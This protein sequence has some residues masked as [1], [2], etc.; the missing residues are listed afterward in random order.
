[1]K[2]VRNIILVT[3]AILVG[4]VGCGSGGDDWIVGVWETEIMGTKM[5]Y[6]FETDGTVTITSDGN[7]FGQEVN[8][9]K[10]GTYSIDGDILSFVDPDSSEDNKKLKISNR[11][12]NAFLGTPIGAPL[13]LE[14][15]RKIN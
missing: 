3:V 15:K 13:I 10:Y 9:T 7:M 2:S 12:Q 14:F 6:K 8:S 5:T 1:M 4:L 11:E